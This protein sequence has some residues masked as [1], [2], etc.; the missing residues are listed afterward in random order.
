MRLPPEKIEEIRNSTD[1]VE[2]IGA[3]VK[4]KKRGK[5]YVGLCPFHNEKTPSFTVSSDKQMYHC[6]GCG[7]GGNSISFMMEFEKISF[8]EAVKSL[9]EKAGISLPVYTPEYDAIANEQE[10]LY[11]ACKAAGL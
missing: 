3:F 5:N 10:E 11:S 2:L 1:I 7:V 8:I 6:F 4:L 9:A